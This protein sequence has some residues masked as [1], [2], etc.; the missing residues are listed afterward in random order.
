[1]AGGVAWIAF[2]AHA[3]H[4]TPEFG[5][6]TDAGAVATGLSREHGSSLPGVLFA[7]AL[8]DASIIGAAAVSLSSVYAIGDL[9]SMRHSLNHSPR[10]AKF[11]YGLYF[12]LIVAAAALV[13]TPGV[14]LGLLTNAVQTLAGVLLLH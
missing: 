4:G 8:I 13:L 12:C 6:V 9:F 5:H 2:C 3:F 7:I 1:M 10:Q 14:P 11:F